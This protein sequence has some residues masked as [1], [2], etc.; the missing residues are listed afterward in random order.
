ML[1]AT[2][3]ASSDGHS[4]V[5]LVLV[6][7]TCSYPVEPKNYVDRLEVSGKPGRV[8]L[9]EASD[10]SVTA[11]EDPPLPGA[12]SRC[13][14]SVATEGKTR[15]WTVLLEIR[16]ASATAHL[17]L[18]NLSAEGIPASYMVT[19]N[20]SSRMGTSFTAHRR[21][22]AA[23]Q[24]SCLRVSIGNGIFVPEASKE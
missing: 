20:D 4:N 22:P 23:M 18:A 7:I 10:K 19:V 9:S 6:V 14:I 2:S 15:E 16:R 21:P 11:Y 3:S 5:R 12:D 17:K 8:L 24:P 13:T 1:L